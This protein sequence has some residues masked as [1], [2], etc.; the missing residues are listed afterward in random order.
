MWPVIT[1]S[2]ILPFLGKIT[3][4][5]VAD[6]LQAFLVNLFALDPFQS[7]FKLRYG[8]ETALL[9]LADNLCLNVDT[10]QAHLVLPHWIYLLPLAQ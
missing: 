7:G 3:E 2:L 9:A 4:R 8:M 5:T 1:L 6:Q 10:D